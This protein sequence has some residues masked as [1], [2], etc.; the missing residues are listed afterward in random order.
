MSELELCPQAEVL[1][2][3]LAR[4]GYVLEDRQ[5]DLIDVVG[6]VGDV[7]VIAKLL[8]LDAEPEGAA[9]QVG[10]GG[11]YGFF[12]GDVPVLLAGVRS[13]VASDLD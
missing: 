3:C 5:S 9:L 2:V 6:E 10:E 8:G 1:E 13:A 11:R 4:V 7:V 12:Q